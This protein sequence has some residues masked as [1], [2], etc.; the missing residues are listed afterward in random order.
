MLTAA[1]AWTNVRVGAHS[2]AAEH[3]A[4]VGEHRQIV[5]ERAMIM[6]RGA[7][8]IEPLHLPSEVRSASG[9]EVESHGVGFVLGGGG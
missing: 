1:D 2:A 4:T 7:P 6:A 3:E 5:L 9:A 8:R